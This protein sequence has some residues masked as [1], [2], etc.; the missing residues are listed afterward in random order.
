MK[1]LM[2][3]TPLAKLLC[4]EAALGQLP[5]NERGFFLGAGLGNY[6]A[7]IDNVDDAN[8]DFDEDESASRIFAGWRF[9]HYVSVQFDRYDFSDASTAPQLLNV[10]AETKGWTP[11]VTGTLPLGPIELSLRA[12]IMFYDVEVSID[13][14]PVIDDSGNDPV[15][16]AGIGLTV[17]EHLALKLEYEIIDISDFSDTEAVWLTAG[18]RF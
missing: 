11:S 6:E 9:N 5:D 7:E 14:A 18:W 12:G 10:T 17:L 15:Y 2:Y 16:A 1:H 8:F 13:N 4:T 3:I